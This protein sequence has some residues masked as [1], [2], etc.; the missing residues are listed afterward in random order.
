[1]YCS[2]CGNKIKKDSDFCGKCGKSI[3]NKEQALKKINIYFIKDKRFFIPF[4]AIL[5]LTL[6][7]TIGFN[8][9]K[10]NLSR[11]LLR[12]WSRVETG[13]S[14]SIY[15]IELD[16][17]KNKI[18]YNFISTYSWLNNTLATY[19]YKIVSPNKIKIKDE[20]YTI[21]FGSSKTTMTITPAL[22]SI[23]DSETWYNHN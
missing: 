10:Y 1:M 22:T 6:L 12:D 16:F 8:I 23:D 3:N 19:E 5:I 20:T 7:F 13:T 11:E 18:E 9:G 2:K 21:K 4:L 14:G 17:S 15:T